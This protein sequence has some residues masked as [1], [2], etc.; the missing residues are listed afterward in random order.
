MQINIFIIVAALFGYYFAAAIGSNCNK[1]SA[2]KLGSR[3]TSDN[4]VRYPFGFP[5]PSRIGIDGESPTLPKDPFPRFDCEYSCDKGDNYA[6]K[7]K[8]TS[9][10][11]ITCC[12]AFC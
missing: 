5:F 9:V 3:G 12:A 11:P 6:P 1:S 2:V 10:P 8:F 4:P 7:C